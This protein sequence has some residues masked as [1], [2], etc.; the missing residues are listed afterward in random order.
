MKIDSVRGSIPSSVFPSITGIL[1]VVVLTLSLSF[2]SMQ[3][4]MAAS[5]NN[6]ASQQ[7]E[8]NAAPEAVYGAAQEAFQTWSRGELVAADESTHVIT[9]LSRTNFFKFVDDIEV[10]IAPSE[11]DTNTTQ[12]TIQSVGR[13]GERD[14]GGNQRNID[15]YINALKG[16][17]RS[18]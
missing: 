5:P 16:L 2:S 14:F 1:T 12:L 10:A 7:I 13:L 15:E 8:I 4:A 11:S 18:P 3:P 17:L 6:Q 9:G